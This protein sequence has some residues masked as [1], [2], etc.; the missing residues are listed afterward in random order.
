MVMVRIGELG[1][2]SRSTQNRALG[3]RV[4]RGPI[5]ITF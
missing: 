3:H 1:I 2:G 5:W 4:P